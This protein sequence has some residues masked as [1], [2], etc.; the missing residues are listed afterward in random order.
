MVRQ[1]QKLFNYTQRIFDI[2]IILTSLSFTSILYT[3]INKKPVLNMNISEAILGLI[4]IIAIH[5]ISFSLF[6][7]YKSRRISD[8]FD[9]L[10][11]II[12][13]GLCSYI[14]IA[15]MAYILNIL[16]EIQIILLG[17]FIINTFLSIL[18][19]FF[20][21]KFLKK[22]RQKGYNQ[23]FLIILGINSCTDSF[24]DKIKLNT[25][26]GYNISGAFYDKQNLNLNNSLN[27][28][29]LLN[30][31]ENFIENNIVDEVI[32]MFQNDETDK[33][34]KSVS[35]CEKWGV[36]FTI[37][38]SIF[39]VLPNRLIIDTFDDLPVLNIRKV[40]LENTANKLIKRLIDI[41]FS[42]IGLVLLSPLMVF[43]STAI[44]LTSKGPIIFKQT[45]VGENRKYFQMYK[46]R[47]MR[48]D[49]QSV[50]KMAEKN[51]DRCTKIGRFIRKYSIDELPQLI[52]VLKGDMSLVGPRPEI[53]HF[54][55][56]FREEIPQYMIK[57][58]IKPGMT[59]WA[60]VNGLRGNTSI[61][62]RIKYDIFYIENWS[63][64]FD[65]KILFLTLTKGIFNK[66]AY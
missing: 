37:V 4:F 24:I 2:I 19:R 42:L 57:H 20:L 8:F 33:I 12:K 52:N 6:N 56:E 26:F 1:N 66:N 63:F 47:S 16:N 10:T 54:V 31:F 23:K 7:I 59:G 40:P 50:I 3:W 53:P 46:F 22:A 9:E 45:R 17:F 13:S 36:K 29:G 60:Q 27:H 58:Y 28:L 41:V 25:Q 11:D 61:E 64:F 38:P 43:I 34:K 44:K 51:D 39:S 32:I 5:L 55:N 30:D 35:I 62:E 49:T 48:I 65:I 15:L 18:Y 14:I 21:R